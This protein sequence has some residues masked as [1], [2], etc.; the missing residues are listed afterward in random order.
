M[1][2]LYRK[3][4]TGADKP[5]ERWEFCEATVERFFGH[6][7]NSLFAQAV[8]NRSERRT[9]VKKIFDYVKHNVAKSISVSP[10]YD[11]ISRCVC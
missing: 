5:L 10:S 8:K 3:A 11:F 9:V 2:D 7:L 1:T 6:L 4:L